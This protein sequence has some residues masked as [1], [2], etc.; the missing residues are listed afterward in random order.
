MNPQDGT[1]S[2][3]TL[4]EAQAEVRRIYLGG[5]VGQ[6]YSGVVW[7]VSAAM[8]TFATESMA[9]V[10][11]L[12][13]GF[14]IYPV[15][16]TVCRILGSPGAIPSTSPLREAGFAIPIVGPLMI[17]LVGAATLYDTRWFFPAFMIAMG[18]HYLPFAV[19]YGVRTFW[20][21]GALMWIG[22]FLIGWLAPGLA[23]VGAWLTGVLLVLF[24]IA[25]ARK[26]RLTHKL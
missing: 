24:S 12:I 1:R 26:V 25:A 14:L 7:L 5:S 20:Y 22:G 11:M 8:W 21:L 23:V 16:T 17:P 18:A 2:K 3:P 19:L 9:I 4:V 6:A 15:T 13:G 10:V